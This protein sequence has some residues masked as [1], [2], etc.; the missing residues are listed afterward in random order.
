MSKGYVSAD[1]GAVKWHYEVPPDKSAKVN[2]LTVGGMQVTG[3]WTGAWGEHYLAWAPLL[4]RDKPR[5]RA[6]YK[7][8]A[9]G[10]DLAEVNRE[11]DL[12]EGAE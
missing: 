5:E 10:R 1:P 7:A 9:E 4:K 8:K 11:F 2:L 3:R 6:L 12:K